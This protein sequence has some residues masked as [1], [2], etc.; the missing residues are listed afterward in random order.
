MASVSH[1]A[2]QARQIVQVPALPQHTL[3][4]ASADSS[5]NFIAGGLG[6]GSFIDKIDPAGN[7]IFSYSNFGGYGF[8]A[9]AG[10]N[11]DVY[12]VGSSGSPVFPFPFTK[13]VLGD[14]PAG[15]LSGFVVRF[16]GSDGAIIWATG[17]G[18]LQPSAVTVDPSGGVVVAGIASSTSP[19]TTSGASSVV[20]T[21]P[22]TPVQIVRLDGNGDLLFAATYGGSVVVPSD[23]PACVINPLFLDLACPRM[24][25]GGIAFDSQGHIWLAGS[26]N[27]SDLP[28]TPNALRRICF[29]ANYAFDGYLAELNADGSRLLYSTYLSAN[30]VAGGAVNALAIDAQDRIWLGGSADGSAVFPS[31][32][33]YDPVANQI[34]FQWLAADHTNSTILGVATGPGGVVGFSGS[35]LADATG[36]TAPTNGFA[37]ILNPSGIQTIAVPRNSVGAGLAVNSVGDLVV[38]GAANVVTKLGL[39]T[40]AAPNILAVANAANLSDATGQIS[41]GE[42]I[43]IFGSG[44]GPTAGIAAAS[45]SGAGAFPSILSGVQVLIDGAAVPLLYV[46]GNQVTAIVPFSIASKQNTHLLVSYQGTSSNTA[47]LGVV[48][49]TPEIFRTGEQNQGF[50]RCG[51]AQSERYDQQP[52]QPC[53]AGRN[54]DSLRDGTRSAL[55]T[56]TGWR[57]DSGS[58]AAP[59]PD[60]ANSCRGGRFRRNALRRARSGGSRGDDANQFPSAGGDDVHAID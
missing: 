7:L 31:L 17:L 41:P 19:P 48:V 29:C 55:A 27:V 11:G 10:P 44:L 16:R 38:A 21:A 36:R 37:G 6:S 39:S 22:A 45:P 1:A 24:T 4:F 47:V 2:I 51:G 50:S 42:I 56:T 3:S 54:R 5:G 12:W 40:S 25:L 26:S 53:G 8:A 14:P 49:A 32:F 28:L 9:A 59:E 52:E 46:S 58:L 23:G 34:T 18:S 60:S 57:I 15:S 43:T 35:P 20:I 30:N 33:T 13:T